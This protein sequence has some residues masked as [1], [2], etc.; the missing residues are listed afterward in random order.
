MGL[1][2]KGSCWSVT[3]CWVTRQRPGLVGTTQNTMLALPPYNSTKAALLQW[4]LAVFGIIV[5]MLSSI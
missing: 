2:S 4:E 1:S 3:V 5:P